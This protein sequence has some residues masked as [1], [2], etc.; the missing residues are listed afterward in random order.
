MIYTRDFRQKN[1]VSDY[2]PPPGYDGN[3]FNEQR[4]M[5]S[6]AAKAE[7]TE[8]QPSRR[9]NTS[10]D[11]SGSAQDG[12][13]F[14]GEYADFDDNP[15]NNSGYSRSSGNQPDYGED[16]PSDFSAG[17]GEESADVRQTAAVQ[18]HA[19]KSSGHNHGI[20]ALSA[21]IESLHGKFGSEEMIILL[22]MLLVASDG[23]GPEVLI[24]ALI[25]IAG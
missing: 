4:E 19:A 22:V 25:L 13:H 5:F 8:R 16:Y 9:N 3:A 11:S 14:S 21:L 1:R 23:I 15:G 18:S 6:S 20:E 7:Y 12:G 24:L 17:D 2:T 10:G